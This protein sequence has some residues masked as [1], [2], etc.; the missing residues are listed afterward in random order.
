MSSG[1]S[2]FGAN[3]LRPGSI[4]GSLPAR[5]GG[6]APARV[7]ALA[8]FNSGLGLNRFGTGVGF[9]RFGNFS[10]FGGFRGFGPGCWN[11]G[12]GFG[13]FGFGLGGF[14]F[15]FGWH[16]WWNWGFGWPGFG[17][18]YVSPLWDD[19]YNPWLWPAYNSYTPPAINYNFYD[20]GYYNPNQPDDNS[21]P[22]DA[23]ASAPDNI[24]ENGQGNPNTSTPPEDTQNSAPVILIFLKNGTVET[25]SNAWLVGGNLHYT[26]TDN[27]N[28]AE[29]GMDQVDWQ[30]TIE[31]NARRGV[32]FTLKSEP[33][34]G[35][36]LDPNAKPNTDDPNLDTYALN[37]F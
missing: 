20:G 18:G 33:S 10:G 16:P 6:I 17:F 34:A 15:G 2:R 13:G 7:G 25:A 29:L 11:C 19:W 28:E 31:E 5:S 37:S 1:Y 12:S 27:G 14:G 30:N 3:A 35:K 9:N 8:G 36:T 32:P 23:G 22:P 21:Y 26:R 24:P 4:G